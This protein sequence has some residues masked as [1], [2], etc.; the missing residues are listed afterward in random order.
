MRHVTRFALVAMAGCMP[1]LAWASS[2]PFGVAMPDSPIGNRI[3]GPLAPLLLFA[4]RMQTQF[5]QKLTSALSAFAHNSHAG[6]WLVAL[7]FGYGV[8]HAVGPGHGKAVIASYL[9]A[10]GDT[11]RRAVLL[12]I[13]ASLLQAVVAIAVVSVAVILFNTTAAA[14]T[15]VTSDIALF[16]Y[17]LV[18]PAWFEPVRFQGSRDDRSLATTNGPE[19]IL[20][21]SHPG[22]HHL[23]RRPAGGQ[24]KHR[25]PWRQLFLRAGGLSGGRGTPHRPE[26]DA[27]YTH[28]HRH[29]PLLGRAH[30]A[31]VRFI[32][33]SLPGRHGIGLRNGLRDCGDG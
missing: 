32:A 12:S 23:G 2:S 9:V 3:S 6:L 27:G 29:T 18:S 16:S 14:V 19:Q 13:A 7:S 33:A 1:G 31:G 30:H 17:A 8:F 5:Y 26:A 11:R 25:S 28:F 20:L 4:M 10:T 15:R 22:G 21:R 24:R